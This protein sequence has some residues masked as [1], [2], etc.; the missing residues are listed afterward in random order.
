MINEWQRVKEL[1]V[2]VDARLHAFTDRDVR[3]YL[4]EELACVEVS[5][6]MLIPKLEQA[7]LLQFS[8]SRQMLLERN[9]WD[10]E[11]LAWTF[12]AQ[13]MEKVKLERKYEQLNVV[14]D[15]PPSWATIVKE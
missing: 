7:A 1:L 5:A 13:W 9:Y 6:L 12:V 2:A 8:V 4:R 15:G 11:R 3:Y 10:A 14:F